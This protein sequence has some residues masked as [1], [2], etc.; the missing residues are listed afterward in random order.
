MVA[1][2]F[3][4]LLSN[5]SQTV[6]DADGDTV[7]VTATFSS[8]F[9]IH[10]SGIVRSDDAVDTDADSFTLSFSKPV[11]NLTFTVGDLNSNG[12]QGGFN[13]RI[14]VQSTL[15]GTPVVTNLSAGTSG[16]TAVY[17]AAFGTNITETVTV[18]GPFDQITLTNFDPDQQHGWLYLTTGDIGNVTCFVDGTLI[19]TG[20]GLIAIENL[21][22]GDLVVTRDRG[23][24]PIRW[25]GKTT[26]SRETLLKSEKLR[27]IRIKS[28][29]LSE[30][31]PNRDL[32]VS[33]QHRMLS[34]SQLSKRMFGEAE[35][36]IAAVRLTGLPDIAI[37]P[38]TGS[39]TYYHLLFDHHEIIYAEGA[40]TESLH[41]GAQ[42]LTSLPAAAKD[43]I[44]TL[45]PELT[46]RTENRRSARQIPTG[47]RQRE[48]ITRLDKNKKTFVSA[49]V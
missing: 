28:G 1:I 12:Y 4:T 21:S 8:D 3:A 34:V 41:T 2:N 32:L 15:D 29:A 10:P 6:T 25:I 33:R 11:E 17:E 19:E 31:V 44:F 36:L 13:D 26:L 18:T 39:V 48:F 47:G 46:E 16:T 24:Q 30:G 5:G 35:V 7:V 23:L 14:E 27:P 37:E 49:S 43:E 42:A 38:L 9:Y 22:Q 40:P 20:G 45:F